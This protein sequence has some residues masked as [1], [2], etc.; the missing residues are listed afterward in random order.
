MLAL[1]VV[2][3]CAQKW[4]DINLAKVSSLCLDRH[5]RAL[6]NEGKDRAKDSLDRLT[7]LP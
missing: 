3:M 1:Q 7:S 6:L 5:K 4:A 2:F